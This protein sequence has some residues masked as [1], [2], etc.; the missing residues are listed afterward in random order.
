MK[1]LA[2]QQASGGNE[3]CLA[4]TDLD[5][6][7]L[8]RAHDAKAFKGGGVE[9]QLHTVD[10][11]PLVLSWSLRR[12]LV[13]NI[14]RF[15]V[16]HIHGL[17]R[18]PPTFAATL[19]R[20]KKVPYLIRPHGALDPFLY[21]RSSLSLPLKRLY[22]R[23]FDLPNLN[24]ASAIHYTTADEM[25]RTKFL[26]LKSTAIIVPNGLDW[27]AYAELPA[28]GAFRGRLGI[29]ASRPLVLFLGRINFKKGLDLLVPAFSRV[30][31]THPDALLAIVG[32]DRE[33]LGKDVRRWCKE[34][35]VADKVV[36]VDHVSADEAV[37]AYVDANVFALSSYT[38]NFGMTVVE[39]MA[40]G[41]PVV[42]SN[43]VNIC[44][45]VQDGNAGLVVGLEIE[46]IGAALS[47]L[48]DDDSMAQAMGAAGRQIVQEKFVWNVIVGRLTEVYR[49]LSAP[50]FL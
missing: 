47:K 15:D 28:P 35:G 13:R 24:A 19:A 20:R 30:V 23:W 11:R 3:V 25:E 2:T 43:E 39:A 50:G 32:P 18:F 36:F 8:D 29:S 12:W 26:Q 48:L 16:V 21:R 49:S 7:S 17:Y 42:I 10:F 22:E 27:N 38:E 44:S 5:Y 45:V 33:R 4:T 40:C 1:S 9:F 46:E 31:Q 6:S 34:H 14:D 37:E 41:C